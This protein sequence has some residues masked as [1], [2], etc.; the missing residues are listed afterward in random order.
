MMHQSPFVAAPNPVEAQCE[1]KPC[2]DS[3]K[4]AWAVMEDRQRSRGK[5]DV[6]RCEY[7]GRWHI[8]GGKK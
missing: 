2:F 6:Y 8:G 7:C 5:R 3:P 4:L 1:G